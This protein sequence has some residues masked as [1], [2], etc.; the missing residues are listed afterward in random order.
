MRSRVASPRPLKNRALALTA[1]SGLSN[2]TG[3][4]YILA[5]FPEQHQ[6]RPGNSTA[7]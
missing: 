4:P 2:I 6:Q 7:R 1:I 5:V 3:M